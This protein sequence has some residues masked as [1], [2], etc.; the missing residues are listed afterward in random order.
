MELAPDQRPECWNAA[1]TAYDEFFRPTMAPFTKAIVARAETRSDM[2]ALDVASGTGFLTF[3]LAPRVRRVLAIDFSEGMLSLLRARATREGVRNVEVRQMNAQRLALPDASFDVVCSNF[4]LNFLPDRV[5][6]FREIHRVLRPGGRLVA[7]AWSALE[8]QEPIHLFME[9]VTRAVP[10]LASPP[11]PPPPFALANPDQFARELQAARFSDVRIETI[12]G[13]V[14]VASAD[15]FWRM[16]STSA[17][18]TVLLL[19]KIGPEKRERVRTN[20]VEIFRSQFGTD[21]ITLRSEA[22]IAVA[23]R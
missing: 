3:E 23:Q 18:P 7:T 9:A 8:R 14:T 21:P 10:D 15:Q 17:P 20:L 4:G 16:V 13:L 5:L 6:G 22:H 19:E 11:E 12:P 1:S 2:E